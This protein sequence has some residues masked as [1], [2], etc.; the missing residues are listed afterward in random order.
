M[1]PLMHWEF[2]LKANEEGLFRD[3]LF[4]IVPAAALSLATTLDFICSGKAANLSLP[5][6][7]VL[8]SVLILVSGFVGF[9]VIPEDKSL[10]ADLF[11]LYSALIRM[12]IFVSLVTELWVSVSAEKHRMHLDRE[13]RRLLG[14]ELKFKALK[15][16]TKRKM[17]HG[18]SS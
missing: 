9:L 18:Q 14:V 16:S 11:D 17:K 4:A 1:Q 15:N 2:F 5:I 12:G 10:D 6:L 8:L 13:R 3:I 7:G